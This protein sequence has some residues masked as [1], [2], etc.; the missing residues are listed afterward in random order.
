MRSSR[1]SSP[2]RAMSPSRSARQTRS[3][4]P[5]PT[6]RNSSRARSSSRH[7]GGRV[8]RDRP[9]SWWAYV[10]GADWKHPEGPESTIVGRENHPVVQVCWDDAVAYARWAG[11][12]LPTEAEWEY[13]A[14]GG[15]EQA[16]YV[17]GDELKPGGR[18]QANIHQG[19]FPIT[20]TAEDGFVATA[21]VASFLPN[22]F[23][24]YDMSG[25]VW[26]WCSDWYRPDTYASS[27]EK[28][29]AG[30]AASFDPDEPGVVKRVQRGG[31]FLCSDEYCIRYLAGARGKGDPSS[32]ASHTGF[33]CVRSGKGPG[34]SQA[35]KDNRK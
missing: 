24:I 34:P 6:R 21:P 32:A 10:P 29:P 7:R 16:R 26:E 11:K 14:R 28:N 22:G 30:P 5:A 12:R 31:S 35:D 19:H 9:L 20:N 23:G 17:W 18:W 3:S 25:N 27:P 13:A 8:D 2:R 1:G 15:L 4:I 33:R